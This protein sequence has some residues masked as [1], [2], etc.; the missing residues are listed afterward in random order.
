[1]KIPDGA[2]EYWQKIAAHT[3]TSDDTGIRAPW[4][5]Q[6]QVAALVGHNA[7]DA[8][9][10]SFNG[11]G[12]SMWTVTLVTASARLIRLRMQFDAEQ[13][14]LEQDRLLSEPLD[15]SVDESWVRR[16]SDVERIDI[17][18]SRMRPRTRDALDVAGVHLIFREGDV[19]DLGVDQVAMTMYD[20]RRRSDGIVDLVRHHTGL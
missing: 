6:V 20:D 10:A 17:R 4:P 13:Y 7:I 8:S 18:S 16:L 3:A 19:V 12:P 15:G 1:M 5:V 14:D 9:V 2:D 11:T